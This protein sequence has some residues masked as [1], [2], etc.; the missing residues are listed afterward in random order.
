MKSAPTLEVSG[1]KLL[2]VL[3]YDLRLAAAIIASENDVLAEQLLQSISP[4][5]QRRNTARDGVP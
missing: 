4:T 1:A 5:Q 2:A 3:N